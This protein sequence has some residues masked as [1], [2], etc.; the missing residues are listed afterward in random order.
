MHC[1][2]ATLESA[3]GI[4]GAIRGVPV[5]NADTLEKK[6]QYRPEF[7]VERFI[8]A[9]CISLP[10]RPLITKPCEKYRLVL[11]TS[12]YFLSGGSLDSSCYLWLLEN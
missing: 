9:S 4:L 2:F 3:T 1:N 5:K 11:R 10:L 7:N 6:R 12:G 8:R